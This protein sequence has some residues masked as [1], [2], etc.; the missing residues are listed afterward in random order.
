MPSHAPS[1][2]I[3][4]AVPAELAAAELTTAEGAPFKLARAWAERSVVLAWVRHFG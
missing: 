4:E 2:V 3:D 1:N